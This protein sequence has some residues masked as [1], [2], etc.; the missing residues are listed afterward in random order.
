MLDVTDTTAPMSEKDKKKAPRKRVAELV[1]NDE[2]RTPGTSATDAGND[3]E[4]KIDS[5]FCERIG[6]RVDVVVVSCLMMLKKEI[7]RR[8]AMQFMIIA[9]AAG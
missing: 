2:A 8:R 5:T 1:R 4:L 3:G 7:D 9:G 6:L